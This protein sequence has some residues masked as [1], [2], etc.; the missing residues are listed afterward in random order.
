MVVDLFGPVIFKEGELV[1][2]WPLLTY[3]PPKQDN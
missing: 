2:A 3:A 1:W